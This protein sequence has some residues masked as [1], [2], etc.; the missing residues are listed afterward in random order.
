MTGPHDEAW[1][2]T[3]I[4]RSSM[5]T[6][7][8]ETYPVAGPP[9]GD[10]PFY[11]PNLIAAIVASVGIV[12]GSVGTW[13]SLDTLSSGGL[14]FHP[15][16]PVTLALGAASAIALF[17]Q[18]NLGRTNFNLRWSVPLCWAVLVAAVGCLAVALVQ[19]VRI[20]SVGEDLGDGFLTQVGWGL[21]L[22]AICAGVLAVVT[23]IVAGQVSRAAEAQAPPGLS[24]WTPGWRWAGIAASAAILVVA[25]FNAYNPTRFEAGSTNTTTATA[26]VTAQ[27]STVIVS[28]PEQHN[29]GAGGQVLPADAT[30]CAAT[31]SDGEFS[32]SAIGSSVTSCGFAEA[33]RRSYLNNPWRNRPVAI[34][35]VS[36]VTRTTY[37]MSC[38]GS[39]IVRCTGGNNAV[40]YLY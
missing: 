2:E 7:G 39:R 30:P 31:F 8:T 26:T 19:I 35:A 24:G 29:S 10:S 34:Q 12:V 18:L 16:G 21:W 5:A 22:I 14:E 17:V 28:D 13:A 25:V 27:P 37:A 4:Y 15:W 6:G 9:L 36:P 33:V 23:P 40:V 38:T 20:R 11:L 3:D 32:S 1:T